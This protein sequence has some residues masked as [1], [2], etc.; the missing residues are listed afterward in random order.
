M[1]NSLLF[2]CMLIIPTLFAWIIH[3]YL[4]HGDLSDK[5]KLFFIAVY[6]FLMN[7]VLYIVS[8]FRGV[9]KL[10]P[11]NMTISF[12][13]KWIGLGIVLGFIVPFIVCLLTEDQI[14]LG[15][16]KRY[17][18]RF[19]NDIHKYTP[20]AIRSAQA[21]LQSE[22]SSSYLNWMWWLIEPLCMM[23]IY[24]IM[25]GFVFR[26]SENYFTAFIYLGLTMWGFFSRNVIASVGI[27]RANKGIINKIYMPKYVL[28]LSKMCVNTFKMLISFGVA[29]LL[30]IYYHVPLSVNILWFVPI[31]VVLFLI[32]FG[33]G[34]IIM[35]Y[36]VFVRDLGYIIGIVLQMFMYMTGTFYNISKRIPAPFGEVLEKYNPIAFLIASMRNILL[37]EKGIDIQLLLF[38]TGISIILIALGVFTVYSNE[39]G[40]VKAI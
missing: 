9:K 6:F 13:A 11:S 23:F 15:G 38:W 26:I 22:V 19:V 7:G 18:R 33:I 21:D 24:A 30:M 5:R 20:Y 29:A 17:I 14:T 12:R 28:L 32:T 40:Y 3:N 36:G 31:I 25:F 10:D 4:R 35:H 8:W 37:Y 2:L 39:N 34:T 16:L 27:V 1:V